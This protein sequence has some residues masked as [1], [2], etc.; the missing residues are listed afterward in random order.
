MEER[1]NFGQGFNG[2]ILFIVV[3][4][5]GKGGRHGTGSLRRGAGHRRGQSFDHANNATTT[6][7]V[8]TSAN[9]ITAKGKLNTTKDQ[10]GVTDGGHRD[11]GGRGARRWGRGMV[12][13]RWGCIQRGRIPGWTSVK[14]VGDAFKAGRWWWRIVEAW[15]N[16]GTCRGG[17][18]GSAT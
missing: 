2:I 9:L 6:T 11:S 4:H 12:P 16:K 8:A 15:V 7:I 3:R 17:A 13:R 5:H 14:G 10:S 18:T 1:H